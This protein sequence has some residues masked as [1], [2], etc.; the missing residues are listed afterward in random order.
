MNARISPKVRFGI[1]VTLSLLVV[2]VV[3][4][5]D[6]SPS[7]A[8]ELKVREE[9]LRHNPI[10]SLSIFELSA[11]NTVQ[12]VNVKDRS[13]LGRWEHFDSFVL[14]TPEGVPDTARNGDLYQMFS[15]NGRPRLDDEGEPIWAEI[16][17]ESVEGFRN[18]EVAT[19]V[20]HHQ[21]FAKESKTFELWTLGVYET[22]RTL[23]R[24]QANIESLNFELS[25]EKDRLA[26][27]TRKMDRL[28]IN[29]EI[30]YLRDEIKYNE[31]VLSRA[32]TTGLLVVRAQNTEVSTDTAQYFLLTGEQVENR[33]SLQSL[34]IP[35][36]EVLGRALLDFAHMAATSR[37]D[38]ESEDLPALTKK[39]YESLK[40]IISERVTH[41]QEVKKLEWSEDSGLRFTLSLQPEHARRFS[42]EGGPIVSKLK[43]THSG[44]HFYSNWVGYY[45]EL[46]FENLIDL[47]TQRAPR[48]V[49]LLH[50]KPQREAWASSCPF[51]EDHIQIGAGLSGLP[52]AHSVY[53][54]W[55]LDDQGDVSVVEFIVDQRRVVEDKRLA[56]EDV[57]FTYWFLEGSDEESSPLHSVNRRKWFLMPNL[58]NSLSVQKIQ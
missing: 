36:P 15:F 55:K 58:T 40:V 51:F 28:Y 3:L 11:L 47:K 17:E 33:V 27:E 5:S 23:A 16:E 44:N 6:L 10:S 46:E 41:T 54:N 24:A 43:S 4:Y 37:N 22:D 14:V 42:T 9:I 57:I 7:S 30:N 2:T 12:M 31:Q 13:L 29:D 18:A 25:A 39:A 49:N 21:S 53:F 50:H 35:D 26:L 48:L 32:R 45:H 8:K 1:S 56:E 19:V 38:R 34:Y 20:R 52:E